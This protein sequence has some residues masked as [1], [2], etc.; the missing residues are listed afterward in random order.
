[1]KKSRK[2]STGRRHNKGNRDRSAQTSNSHS[3]APANTTF[4]ADAPDGPPRLAENVLYFVLPRKEST[5][6]IGDLAE[7]YR[8]LRPRFGKR[9]ADYWYYKEA[10][11]L[12][13][14]GLAK[15]LKLI[16]YG[17]IA[18]LIRKYVS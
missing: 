11:I 9:C 15:I 2:K 1:M 8:K 18:Y 7:H 17:W 5:T 10:C 14:H 3:L 12:F 6:E 13:C 16:T 4:T